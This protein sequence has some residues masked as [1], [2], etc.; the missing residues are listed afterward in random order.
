MRLWKHGVV[1]KSVAS[2]VPVQVRLAAPM[3]CKFSNFKT[4]GKRRKQQFFLQEMLREPCVAGS[5][6]APLINEWVAQSVEQR[7]KASCI[8]A[9]C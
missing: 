8:F 3:V 6:P 7:I 4:Y 1:G 2:S 9:G 5:N